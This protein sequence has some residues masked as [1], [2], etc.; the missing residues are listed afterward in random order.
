MSDRYSHTSGG[1]GRSVVAKLAELKTSIDAL[2]TTLTN[3]ETETNGQNAEIDTIR[4]LLTTISTQSLFLTTIDED[5]GTLRTVLGQI[6]GYMDET[7]DGAFAD[8]ITELQAIGTDG[9]AI[10]TLIASTNTLITASNAL[11]TTI[12]AFL[13]TIAGNQTDGDQRTV[14][15]D[16][17]GNQIG[18]NSNAL[19]VSIKQAGNTVAS[20]ANWVTDNNALTINSLATSSMLY[21][22]DGTYAQPLQADSSKNLKVT[23]D[24][25]R[26]TVNFEK[27]NL[28]ASESFI[29]VDLSD[30][31]SFPHTATSFVK[32]YAIILNV[33]GDTSFRGDIE[34]GFIEEV[35]ATDSTT[36]PIKTIHYDQ[37]VSNI[38]R[39]IKFDDP[40]KCAVSNHLSNGKNTTNTNFQTD[41]SLDS[42][43]GDTS[44]AAGAGD[45]YLDLTRTAGSVDISITLVYD[46]E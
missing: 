16:S 33:N 6:E 21:A 1:S 18:S 34:I 19:E 26:Y 39:F 12:D 28:S 44:S 36:H 38:D 10:Q 35:D 20:F 7:P 11:L 46:T 32:I 17:I 22:D 3:I 40:I 30:S 5:T 2:E 14:I 15:Q 23:R 9:N 27:E 13:A 41:V 29:L 42:P 31:A 25:P 45:I 37:S 8:I 4:T 43:K 24:T